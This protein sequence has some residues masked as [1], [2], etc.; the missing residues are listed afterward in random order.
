M[1]ASQKAL[2]PGEIGGT[3]ADCRADGVDLPLSPADQITLDGDWE[4]L[5]AGHTHHAAVPTSTA[6]T[7]IMAAI[8]GRGGRPD[9]LTP[10]N[11]TTASGGVA[12]LTVRCAAGSS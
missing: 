4:D 1:T 6:V 9:A 8:S 3:G 11:S 10:G 7:T 5:V 12:T 2:C